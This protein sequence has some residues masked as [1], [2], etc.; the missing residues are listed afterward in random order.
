VGALGDNGGYMDVPIGGGLHAK[1]TFVSC[2]G[3]TAFNIPECPTANGT[4][5]G[6]GRG[7]FSVTFEIRSSSQV[8][9]R[10]TTNFEQKAK[11]HGEVGSDAKLKSIDVEHTEEL[12]IVATTAGYP[13]VIRAGVTRKVHIPMPG[14]HYD[15]ASA[16]ARFFG[17]P[18]KPDSG[19]ESFA[20]TAKAA[21]SSYQKA[22]ERWSS[23]N[24]QPF[25]AEPVFDPASNA[26]KLK[27]GEKKQLTVYAKARAD[28]G[29]ATGARWTLL[30][31]LNADFS[32]MASED[33]SPTIQYTVTNSPAGDQV[34]VMVKVTSTAGVGQKT[35]TQPIAPPGRN[36]IVGS[37]NGEF[38]GP[39]S[40][41][42]RTEQTWSGTVEFNRFGTIE[43]SE[44][45]TLIS[46]EV[47]ITASGLDG[48]GIS[49]C[50]QH[51]SNSNR[52]LPGGSMEVTPIGKEGGAPYEY[53]IS[54]SMPF[55]A[56]NITRINCNKA[57]QE[58]GYEGTEYPLTPLYR[59]APSG[60]KSSDGITF[61]GTVDESPFESVDL[62]RW[63]LHG[64]E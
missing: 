42:G 38:K 56:L 3:V 12:F 30:V 4:V 53:S 43:G 22:E 18:L 1:V 37:F 13:I 21:I 32:P 17:D 40:V 19:A 6:R 48:S 5:D 28:G 11:I 34:R 51:G 60:Q 59:F 61:T 62:Q 57:S 9:S 58:E 39:Q 52:K 24:R 33:A 29:R 45:Y 35:W 50:Q 36:Q 10:S 41:E 7:E 23:F 46:G 8:F 26:I 16:S 27:T 2:G 54:V 14:G 25:C 31:P 55:E 47:S 49:G 64:T 63:N 15:P 20:N 44:Y